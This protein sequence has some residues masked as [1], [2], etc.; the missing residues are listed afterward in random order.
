MIAGEI[1]DMEETKELIVQLS[2]YP[3]SIIA[4]GL[5]D[6]GLEQFEQ[7]NTPGVFKDNNNN[8]CV[9]RMI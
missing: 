7:F 5:S 6:T 4:I 3:C 9:R 2:H 1:S 8:G